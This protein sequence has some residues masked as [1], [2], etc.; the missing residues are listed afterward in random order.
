MRFGDF[1]LKWIHFVN[2][3]GFLA[4][5]MENGI[6]KKNVRLKQESHFATFSEKRNAFLILLET[7]WTLFEWDPMG[8]NLDA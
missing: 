7:F 4:S 3:E 1:G 8:L 2:L 5:E 6:F